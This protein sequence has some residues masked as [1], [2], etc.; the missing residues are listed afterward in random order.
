VHLVFDRV[1]D[2]DDFLVGLINTLQ[3]RVERRRFAASGRTGDQEN[4]VRHGRVMLHPAKHP[5]IKTE[6]AQVV[7]IARRTVQQAHDNALAIER[8]QRRNTKVH[9]AAHRFYFD[10]PILRQAAFGDVQLGHQ[11]YA[12]NNSGLQLA[13]RR[14]LAIE[15]AV[16]AIPDAELF[17]ERLDMYVARALLDGLRDHRVHQPDDWRFAGHVAKMLK[18]FGS[19]CRIGFRIV[20]GFVLL[21]VIAG[22][23]VEDLLLRREHGI[24]AE[25]GAG[26]HRGDGLEIERVGHRQ[27]YR[28]IRQA[29]RKAAELAQEFRRE[30]FRFRGNGG[31]PVD[32]NQW[33]AELVAQRRQHIAHGDEAEIYQRLAELVAAFFLQLERAIEILRRNQ[34][35]RNQRFAEPHQKSRSSIAEAG[36]GPPARFASESL[37][38]WPS[39]TIWDGT[40]LPSSQGYRASVIPRT[41]CSS[42]GTLSSDEAAETSISRMAVF[43]C[44]NLSSFFS[45]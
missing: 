45:R 38:R 21:A 6:L 7:K 19:L 3:S 11:L 18:V 16:N 42:G 24:D 29:D 41:T 33:N 15:H 36:A 9:F 25:A 26:A 1:F 30:C 37:P 8:G 32:G 35:A 28:M 27:P 40:P 5:V 39:I 34:L 20:F 43:S 13:R 22:D 10:A 14:V 17:F 4:A 12:R 31:R 44:G 2:G 23:R